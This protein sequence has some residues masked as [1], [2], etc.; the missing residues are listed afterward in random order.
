M[1]T[2]T[3]IAQLMMLGDHFTSEESRTVL[4]F[5]DLHDLIG[6]GYVEI[7]KKYSDYSL[8]EHRIYYSVTDLGKRQLV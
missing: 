7:T 8:F 5:A 3:V 6:D 4:S 1:D 2:R